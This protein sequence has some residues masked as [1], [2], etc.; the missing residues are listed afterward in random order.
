MKKKF[1]LE[2]DYNGKEEVVSAFTVLKAIIRF[3]C[4]R[5]IYVLLC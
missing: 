5:I 2:M 3:C 4:Q 1:K